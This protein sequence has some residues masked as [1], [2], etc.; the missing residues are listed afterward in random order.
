[1]NLDRM[2][3]LCRDVTNRVSTQKMQYTDF[4]YNLLLLSLYID[5][6][7]SFDLLQEVKVHWTQPL[8]KW[9]PSKRASTK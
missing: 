3:F 6:K 9:Q 8:H 7:I 5:T 4:P 2:H 1:M